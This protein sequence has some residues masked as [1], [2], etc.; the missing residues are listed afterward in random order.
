MITL[1]KEYYELKPGYVTY[2]YPTMYV[3]HTEK[4]FLNR[5]KRIYYERM[6]DD[7]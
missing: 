6:G 7:S 4:I 3:T 1:R 2:E 5:I